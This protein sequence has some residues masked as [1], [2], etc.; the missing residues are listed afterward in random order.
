MICLDSFSN[1]PAAVSLVKLVLVKF[2]HVNSNSLL[3]GSQILG[4]FIHRQ[5]LFFFFR[6]VLRFKTSAV[7]GKCV[8]RINTQ[9]HNMTSGI[10]LIVK[11]DF[12]RGQSLSSWLNSSR[13]L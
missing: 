6:R 12:M 10:A 11:N 2:P 7:T 1:H 3:L 8:G 5:E 4:C 9:G 13:C